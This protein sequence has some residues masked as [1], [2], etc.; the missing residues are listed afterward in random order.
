MK[1]WLFKIRDHCWQFSLLLSEVLNCIHNYRQLSIVN[2]Y[3]NTPF[4]QIAIII[5]V[6]K[7]V[8]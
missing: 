3:R 4:S 8:F 2:N 1:V 7:E 6:W 5:I